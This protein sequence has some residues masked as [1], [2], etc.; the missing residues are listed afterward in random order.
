MGVGS[1]H[2]I[3]GQRGLPRTSVGDNSHETE[4][5]LARETIE[6]SEAYEALWLHKEEVTRE[7]D[8]LQADLTTLQSQVAYLMAERNKQHTGRG[9]L[10]MEESQAAGGGEPRDELRPQAKT[11]PL[12]GEPETPPQERGA[13]HPETSPSNTWSHHER[14]FEIG[15]QLRGE[16]AN[17]LI[18][19]VEEDAPEIHD[20]EWFL[21]AL[22]R[23]FEEPLAE[24]KARMALQRLRQGDCV[25]SDFV[26]EFCRLASRLRG[27]PEMVLVQLLKDA[28]YPKIL[29]WSLVLGDPGTLMDWIKRAGEAELRIHQESVRR[30]MEMQMSQVGRDLVRSLML[31]PSMHG[32][33]GKS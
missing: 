23:R 22:R 15:T 26:A 6:W 19:L 2:D 30:T 12:H 28:L 8:Q 25:V 13:G 29:Q 11:R 9:T 5:A 10:A 24:E 14:V 31:L 1:L 33:S 20:L 4:R 17:W 27:W 16:A 3:G 21:V 7:R 18:G 32:S